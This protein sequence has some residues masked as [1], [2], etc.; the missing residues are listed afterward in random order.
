MKMYNSRIKFA[1]DHFIMDGYFTPMQSTYHLK[2]T[3][4]SGQYCCHFN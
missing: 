2:E 3:A 1:I 4:E